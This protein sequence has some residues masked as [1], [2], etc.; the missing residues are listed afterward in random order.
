[1]PQL[2]SNRMAQ[3]ATDDAGSALLEMAQFLETLTQTLDQEICNALLEE[4]NDLAERLNIS[5]KQ[6]KK[7]AQALADSSSS[8]K[9]R[10]I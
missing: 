7:L 9:A 1:M 6:A 5:F 8:L 2:S 10:L 4:N 3:P